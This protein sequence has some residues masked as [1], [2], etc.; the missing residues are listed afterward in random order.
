MIYELRTY[1]AAPGQTERI[2]RRFADH[3]RRLF[4]KHGIGMVGFWIPTDN[5]DCLVY[6]L[7]F[8]DEA[9]MKAAWAAFAADPEWKEAK[10]ASEVEGRL[11]RDFTSQVLRAT[12]YSPPV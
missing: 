3:T 5:P 7:K 10:A 1:Y 9:H 8:D 11:V 4:T 2:H 6:M 12:D